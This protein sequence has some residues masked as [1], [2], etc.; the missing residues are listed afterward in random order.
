[1]TRTTVP[2]SAYSLFE[3]AMTSKKQ[4]LC[5]Y[6]G[7]RRELCPVILGHTNGREVVLAYQFA[8]Q[9]KG[10]LPP[11]ANGNAYRS[12]RSAAFSFATAPGMPA[13]AT[14]RRKFACKRSI[15]M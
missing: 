6:D 5:T 15:S 8:G 3:Q 2:S 9:S 4:I 14:P 7:Y 12:S 11:G 1:M 13:R 10:G